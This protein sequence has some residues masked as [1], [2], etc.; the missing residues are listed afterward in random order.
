MKQALQSKSDPHKKAVIYCR[1]SGQ[2]QVKVGHGLDSQETRC[3]EY[4]KYKS[5]QLVEVFTDDLSG[6]FAKRPGM[7]AM[8][9]YLRK[10]RNDELIVIIDDISRLARG[11]EA[12]LALRSSINY[13][14]GT[15]ESPSIEFGEDSD[16]ILVE[17]LLAS[18]SQHQRQKNAEQTK[19]RMR[20]RVMNGYW[21]FSPPIGY[22]YKLVKGHGKLL[23]PQEP[24]ASLLK[25]AL[26]RFADGRLET[27][28]EVKHFLEKCAEFPRHKNGEIH[29]QRV[30]Q[31]LERSIYAGYITVK[32][33]DIHLLKGHHEP[34][35]SFETYQRIQE[36][37]NARSKAPVRK[38]DH[39]DFALRGFV[40]CGKCN[41]P[42]T[43]AW[44]KG[45]TKRYAYYFCQK[46]SCSEYRKSIRKE[47]IETDFI[48]LL[49]R[50]QPDVQT[51]TLIK[52][53]LKDAWD[54]RHGQIA[55]LR[56]D[57]QTQ[58]IATERKAEQLMD[59]I[60]ETDKLSL[61]PAYEAQIEKLNNKQLVIDEK[62]AN[63]EEPIIS[64]ED[65][66]ETA[67]Q[68]LSNP[69]KLW[70]SGDLATQ[71]LILK[72]VFEEKLAYCRN[73]GYRTPKISLPFKILEAINDNRYDLV[74]PRRLELPRVLP[75]SDLNAARLPVPPRPHAVTNRF[76]KQPLVRG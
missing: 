28:V 46:K 31:L 71:K 27:P 52:D 55:K 25:Q 1:V 21:S 15:L 6:K 72:L 61:I 3:R 11:L 26:E 57:L 75:H 48:Y 40:T 39:A 34:L 53:I 5:Y 63:L 24:F 51:H 20:A 68:F 73:G 19:N 66:C 43:G 42:M 41:H 13:A 32:K 8:L 37:L 17:N 44:A 12:H 50:L 35:I 49:R 4:A 47:K 33:W 59:R 56:H 54:E 22:K 76:K 70:A 18:V 74:R 30:R 29:F 64:F 60:V 67:L 45:K 10:Y 14:G 65:T 58:L 23:V 9:S 7:K 69:W 2:K 16:S 38:S 62:I 36:R